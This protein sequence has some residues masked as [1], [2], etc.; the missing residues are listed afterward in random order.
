MRGS[1]VVSL[2]RAEPASACGGHGGLGAVGR[3]DLAAA[4]D[5]RRR[6]SSSRVDRLNLVT[7]AT[8]GVQRRKA[9]G[10]QHLHRPDLSVYLGS[11][12]GGPVR[13]E[14]RRWRWRSRSA[15]GVVMVMLGAARQ[16]PS[17]RGR[18]AVMFAGALVYIAVPPARDF[19]TSGPENGL[20]TAWLGGL[21]KRWS[22]GAQ[23][24]GRTGPAFTAAL[25]PSL[26]GLSVLVR[27]ELRVDRRPALVMMLIAERGWARRALIVVAGGLLPVGY[28]IFRMGYYGPLV[29]QTAIAGGRPGSKWDQGMVHLRNFTG[30]YALWVPALLLIAIAVLLGAQRAGDGSPR[31]GL[32]ARIQSPP[33][34]WFSWSSAE[35]CR[36]LIRQGGATSCTDG[37]CSHPLFC[38][39]AP[40]AV[41]PLTTRRRLADRGKG[42]VALAALWL[43]LAGW[44][45][46]AANSPAWAATPP[47]SPTPG[48]SGRTP[49]LPP[50][51]GH[52][53][54]A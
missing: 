34:S 52:A 47:R 51:T 15:A 5:Q 13:L 19:A 7:G 36:D 10:V 4:L 2:H 50:A 38:L 20:V 23:K 25:A 14:V 24:P 31:A 40:V 39:L 46:W 27:P 35:C 43:A 53:P 1:A 44:A 30:P 49:V 21:V 37:C 9:G 3:G 41:I 6:P 32:A 54:P 26:A 29:P 17:L 8:P 28:Q 11:L 42:Y 12:V 22:A 33:R 18:R 16:A 48:S 45:L